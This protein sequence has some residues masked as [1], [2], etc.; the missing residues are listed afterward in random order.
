MGEP[1]GDL[2]FAEEAIRTKSRGQLRP[3]HLHRH[4]AIVLEVLGE[5]DRRHPA[6]AQHPL[7]LVAAGQGPFDL[8]DLDDAGDGGPGRNSGI[9]RRGLPQRRQNCASS[10]NGVLQ[11][12]H[13]RA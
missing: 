6:F 4:T 12:G 1:C 7:D 9:G 13:S 5:V 8:R 10:G 3:H 2:H 11:A